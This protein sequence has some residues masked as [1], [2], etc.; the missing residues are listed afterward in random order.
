MNKKKAIR[1][2]DVLMDTGENEQQLGNCLGV[3]MGELG[4]AG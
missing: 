4:C 1:T 2:E 3:A